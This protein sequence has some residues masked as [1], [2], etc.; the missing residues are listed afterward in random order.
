MSLRAPSCPSLI[1]LAATVSAHTWTPRDPN[2]A[3]HL[4]A[5]LEREKM[6][7]DVMESEVRDRKKWRGSGM[8]EKVNI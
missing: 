8:E 7:D 1:S 6:I 4:K 2:H 5:P 3:F